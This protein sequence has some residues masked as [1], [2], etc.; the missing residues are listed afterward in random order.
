MCI[1][2]CN[3][4]DIG[5]SSD[6]SEISLPIERL[7]KTAQKENSAAES[8]GLTCEERIAAFLPIELSAALNAYRTNLPFIAAEAKVY[9]VW[10]LREPKRSE[11]K[12]VTAAYEALVSARQ[13]RL[14]IRDLLDH[15]KDDKEFLRDVFLSEGYFF[16]NN[17]KTAIAEAEEITLPDLFDDD[18]IY[19][20]RNN[21][22]EPLRR[23]NSHYWD[24]AGNEAAFY[25]ND[26]VSSS[27]NDLT[28][29]FHLDF[30][31]VRQNT[32][33]RRIVPNA[34]G[35]NAVAV[36]LEFGFGEWRPALLRLIGDRTEVECI[37]GDPATLADT[38]KRSAEIRILN[39]GIRHAAAA[40][41]SERP[42]FDEPKDEDDFIQEDGE[43]R[44]AW[45]EAY[46]GKKKKYMYRELEYRVF[47]SKGNPVPPQVC[48]DFILDTWE[49]AS[50]TWYT[51]RKHPP[52]RT[53]GEID[54]YSLP[55]FGR[56][57][58]ATILNYAYRPESPFD[59]Y[60]IPRRDWIPMKTWRRFV[61]N[62][63]KHADHYR[64][65]DILVIHGLRDEDEMEHFHT[66]LI[67]STDLITGIPTEVADNQGRPRISNLKTAL[68]AAPRRS[69][70]YRLRLDF[71]KMKAIT[72]VFRAENQASRPN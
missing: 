68:R 1:C 71:E 6:K 10:Y 8:P 25:L 22:I 44:Q 48:V 41:V 23:G 60:D 29:P 36:Q 12:R 9:P 33:A 46:F 55:N 64:E 49:R 54:F 66:V 17:A 40:A 21:I 61:K 19:R 5:A 70:K 42:L 3:N 57:H 7:S 4:A 2:G 28:K 52:K 26:R 34:Q 69:I 56:R 72:A 16:E 62:L 18:V 24:A 32:E 47:D 43:L 20:L 65:G 63:V 39:D 30:Q 38:M 31:A 59:R 50:G 14:R 45:K 11:S 67:L 13:P 53:E 51:A 27:P 37:G 58:I 15:R 35:E